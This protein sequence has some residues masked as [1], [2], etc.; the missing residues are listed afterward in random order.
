M[1]ANTSGCQC[2]PGVC[3][4]PMKIS[5][6]KVRKYHDNKETC[7]DKNDVADGI[8][9]GSIRASTEQDADSFVQW[10]QNNY[11][12]SLYLFIFYVL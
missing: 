5:E 10:I 2:N 3:F 8:P 11:A 9:L 6:A 4:E 1:Q 7:G 12:F